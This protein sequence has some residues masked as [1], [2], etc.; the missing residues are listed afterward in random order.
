VPAPTGLR[1]A[2]RFVAQPASGFPLA[3]VA[4]A[5]ER[6]ADGRVTRCAIGVTGVGDMPYRATEAEAAVLAGASFE[7]AAGHVVGDRRVASDI[8]ADRDYRSAMAVAMTRR[9]LEIATA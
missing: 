5:L 6:D 7:E 9:A 3:G 1:S 4:A 8:H 2:Y